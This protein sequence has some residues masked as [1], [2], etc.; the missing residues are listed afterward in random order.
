MVVVRNFSQAARVNLTGILAEV[1]GNRA[2][3][4]VAGRGI[5]GD[6]DRF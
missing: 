5:K 6:I 1:I 3:G 2:I 4:D